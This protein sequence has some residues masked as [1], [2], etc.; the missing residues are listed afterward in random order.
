MSSKF[1]HNLLT[2]AYSLGGFRLA[3][4]LT[5]NQPRILMYHR[6]S[7]AEE[8]NKV[9]ARVFD[10]QMFELKKNFNVLPL[11]RIN[12]CIRQGK[13]AP[14]NSIIITI[15]DGY[16]DFYRIA[17]PI[18]KKYGLPATIYVTTD[19]IDGDLWLW[20]DKVS[21]ILKNTGM[22][23]LI[24]KTL[25]NT[26]K[27]LSLDKDSGR[28]VAWSVVIDFCLSLGEKE[29]RIFI[30][31]MALDLEVSIGPVPEPEYAP[32]SWT[33][34][35]VISENG[36]EIGAHSRTHP[37]LSSLD[38]ASLKDE[39]FGSKK[40]IEESISKP[41]S[42]FCYPNG[43]PADYNE[44]VKQVVIESGFS[45]ATT[46]FH[47]KYGWQDPFEIRRNGVG[48]EMFQFRQAAYGVEYLSDLV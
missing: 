17:Y 43:Q 1:K 18:L 8:D 47:D 31:N 20:P 11:S 5:R 19:F 3:R 33:A 15:D 9:S 38:M 48:K 14:S 27:E 22:A 28:A 21:Y 32:M 29:R 34:I 2:R 13:P 40:I 25:D 44:Q 39:I 36:I 37:V 24:L 10:R 30:D 42:A 26:T 4:L 45:S 41:V 16:E 35:R 6:F 7:E 23:K 12:D 46:A